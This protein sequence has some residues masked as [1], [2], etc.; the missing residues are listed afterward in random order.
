MPPSPAPA[1][2]RTPARSSAQLG[3]SLRSADLASTRALLESL[4]KVVTFFCVQ[5]FRILEGAG[6]TLHGEV[7]E[8]VEDVVDALRDYLNLAAAG[9][10]KKSELGIAAVL[11]RCGRAKRASTSNR[12]AVGRMITL[13]A[14]NVR[15]VSRELEEMAAEGRAQEKARSPTKAKDLTQGER[16][17]R[18]RRASLGLPVEAGELSKSKGAGGAKG[19]RLPAPAEGPEGGEEGE[20]Y[21]PEYSD[22]DLKVIAK[23]QVFAQCMLALL[24][25]G[26]RGLHASPEPAT[27]DALAASEALLSAAEQGSLAADEL[28]AALYPPQEVEEVQ[29]AIE[30]G[31]GAM[32]ALADALRDLGRPGV[33]QMGAFEEFRQSTFDLHA[34][35]LGSL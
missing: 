19:C 5:G 14:A 1:L 7:Q 28:G 29:A 20:E 30:D 31:T 33:A 22:Q 21:E 2:P 18:Q 16:E 35:L 23:A 4:E 3:L 27:S 9:D 13:R 8:V 32:M 12:V 24:K 15:S 25:E 11:E 26:I 17:Q 10:W 34:V 6:A